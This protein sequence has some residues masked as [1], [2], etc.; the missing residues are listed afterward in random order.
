[1]P[2]VE[3]KLRIYTGEGFSEVCYRNAMI[4]E[5][6]KKF[7]IKPDLKKLASWIYIQLRDFNRGI[8]LKRWKSNGLP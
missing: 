4:V 5:T 3:I 7:F 1:M 2:K 8:R 6:R